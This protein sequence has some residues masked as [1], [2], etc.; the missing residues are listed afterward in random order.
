M[1]WLAGRAAKTV[2]CRYQLRWPRFDAIDGHVTRLARGLLVVGANVRICRV[3]SIAER[4]RLTTCPEEVRRA[5]FVH[6]KE[7]M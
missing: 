4:L 6:L 5:S 3:S 7:V 2:R 1:A